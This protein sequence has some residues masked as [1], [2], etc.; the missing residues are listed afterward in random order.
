MDQ[1]ET[2]VVRIYRRDDASVAGIVEAVASGE[3]H[4]FHDATTR[5]HCDDDE[6]GILRVRLPQRGPSGESERLRVAP[7]CPDDWQRS[8]AWL[9]RPG[10]AAPVSACGQPAKDVLDL[11][12]V[13]G[14]RATE[15]SAGL[16]VA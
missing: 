5:G 11:H 1:T 15:A 9:R 16:P 3:Q 8:A 13:D 4:G 2:Y 10:V 6:E 12:C 7:V 14:T